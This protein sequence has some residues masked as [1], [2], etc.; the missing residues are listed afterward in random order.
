MSK[1]ISEGLIQK[2]GAISAVQ[3]ANAYQSFLVVCLALALGEDYQAFQLSLPQEH[4]LHMPWPFL[5]H[6][7]VI[8]RADGPIL[9]T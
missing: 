9:S 3:P 8:D 4:M 7:S 1:T 2:T 6:H 5:L